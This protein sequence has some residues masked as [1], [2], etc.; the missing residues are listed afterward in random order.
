MSQAIRE[1]TH[2]GSWYLDDAELLT[3]QLKSFIKNPTPETGKRF[4]ISPYV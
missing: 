3:K 1:A 4:V 2:A